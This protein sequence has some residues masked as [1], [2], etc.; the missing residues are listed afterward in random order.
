[1]KLDCLIQC[2]C[3]CVVQKFQDAL[4]RVDVVSDYLMQTLF[5]S[6]VPIYDFHCGLLKELDQRLAIWSAHALNELNGFCYSVV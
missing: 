3:C 4:S 1:M 5:G 2:Q 6:I